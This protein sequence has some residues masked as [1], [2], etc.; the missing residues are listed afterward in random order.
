MSDEITK[1]DEP[2]SFT[3]EQP[4]KEKVEEIPQEEI[5]EQD[6]QTVKGGAVPLHK[7]K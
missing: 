6:A 4:E 3:N 2:A 1:K 5:T 7:Y